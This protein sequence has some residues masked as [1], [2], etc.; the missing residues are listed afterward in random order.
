MPKRRKRSIEANV[1]IDGREL[2]WVLR[3]EPQV[4]TEFGHKG[5]SFSV[6][7]AEGVRRELILEFPFP[8][9]GAKEFVR[10]PE[11][12]KIVPAAIEAAIRQA[13]EAGWRPSSRGRPFIFRV[14]EN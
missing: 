8:R 12:P 10:Y 6:H 13:I 14:P 5:M 2:R 4:T 1:T 9:N 3:S 11:P 7:L